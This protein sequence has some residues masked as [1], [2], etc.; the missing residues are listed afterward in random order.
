MALPSS[1][2]A[3]SM[4]AINVE[5]GLLGVA[6]STMSGQAALHNPSLSAPHSMSEWWGY[7]HAS[8]PSAPTKCNTNNGTFGITAIWFDTSS[9]ETGFDIEWSVNSGAFGNAQTVGANVTT[10][11]YSGTCFYQSTY[12]CRVRAYN[13]SG[14]SAWCTDGSPVTA[15]LQCI[16]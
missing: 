1:P 10:V 7:S 6:Q 14:D 15:G 12:A 9:D 16:Q 8:P 5:L 3:L 2:N 13:A 4:N 11:N